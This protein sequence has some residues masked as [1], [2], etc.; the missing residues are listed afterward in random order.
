[1]VVQSS[2]EAEYKP[3]ATEA[4][5]QAVWLPRLLSEIKDEDVRVSVLKIDNKSDISLIKNPYHLDRSKHIDIKYH[6]L[7]EYESSG[8]IQVEFIRPEDQ[9]HLGRASLQR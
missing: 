7:Q 9:F 2:C 6:V 8:Q 1:V 4:A 5:C 3:A